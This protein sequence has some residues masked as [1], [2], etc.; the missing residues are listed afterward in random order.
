ME[1]KIKIAQIGVSKHSHGRQI[2]D[3]LKKQ[4]DIFEIVGYALPEN[5]REKFPKQVS[6]FDGCREMTVEEILNDP[7]I[8]AVTIETEEIYLTKYAILAAKHGKHVHM[9]KPG[10]PDMENFQRLI[11]TARHNK[12]VL[13]IGYMY[14]YNPCVTQ[15]MEQVKT[16]ELGEIISVEAQM[17]CIHP[18]ETRQWLSAFPGGMMFFLGCHLVDLILQ[19]Q[20]MPERIIPL[21]KCSGVDGVTSEDFGMAVLEYQNG[22]SFAKT[23]AVET[24]GFA[25]RQLVVSGTKKTVE[26]KPLEMTMENGSPLVYTQKTEYESSVWKDM[27]ERLRTEPFDRYDAMMAAFATMA[28]GERENPYTYD[29]ELELFKTVLACCGGEKGDRDESNFSE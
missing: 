29:Y 2:F 16:G 3:S 15:L 26:L 13:H 21:N 4:E 24:G 17:N 22:V 5:E 23:S 10:S 25:R 14:R 18:A 12:T 8:R 7:E 11:E 1:G 9:E 6:C 20:G 27:G 28:R 19:L